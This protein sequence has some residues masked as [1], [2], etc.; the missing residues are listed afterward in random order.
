[1]SKEKIALLHKLIPSL[2]PLAPILKII[3]SGDF[4]CGSADKESACNAG[5]LDS[6]PGLGRSPG[7]GKGYPLQYSGLKNCIV[8]GVAKSW[9]L[10]SNFHFH[11]YVSETYETTN[12]TFDQSCT[13]EISDFHSLASVHRVRHLSPLDLCRPSKFTHRYYPEMWGSHNSRDRLLFPHMW[14]SLRCC[15]QFFWTPSKNCLY[16][17]K[18]NNY[19][20]IISGFYRLYS[21]FTSDFLNALKGGLEGINNDDAHRDH[22]NLT[23]EQIVKLG[24]KS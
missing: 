18:K 16:Y 22:L 5:D 12:K 21:C 13:L 19:F 14:L 2:A 9:T 15:G 10:L 6:V 7:K 24:F 4:S 17:K 1:M 20:E 8:H 3:L 23:T 11:L